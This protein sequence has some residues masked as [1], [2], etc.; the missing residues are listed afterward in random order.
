MMLPQFLKQKS[1]ELSIEFSSLSASEKEE[2]VTR[3]QQFKAEN[4]DT[5]RRLSNLAITRAV[6]SKL[7]I[8]TNMVM[9]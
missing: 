2:L 1:N 7:N 6:N 4:D 8:I 3:H 9:Y 5:A